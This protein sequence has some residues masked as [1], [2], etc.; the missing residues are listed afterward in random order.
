MAKIGGIEYYLPET[1]LSN[2]DIAIKFPEWSV[3]KIAKKTG[4]SKRH[5]S[6]EDEF[7]SD[8]ALKACEKFFNKHEI[9]THK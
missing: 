2:E 9:S 6:R 7:A 1:E 3:E 4:I 8:L 5:I